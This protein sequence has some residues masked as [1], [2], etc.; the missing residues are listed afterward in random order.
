MLKNLLIV[1]LALCAIIAGAG[2][3]VYANRSMLADK[4]VAYA[5]NNLAG[6]SSQTQSEA[7]TWTDT[8]MQAGMKSLQKSVKNAVDKQSSEGQRRNKNDGLATM[9]DMF[10][11]A[12][13]SDSDNLGQMAQVLL[14]EFGNSAGVN[15]S[16]LSA[17]TA[18]D[19]NARD[20]K[21]RTLLMNV[22]RVDVTPRVVKMLLKQGADDH[23]GRSALMYAA[24]LNKNPEVVSCLLNNGA[25]VSVV[26]AE[27]KSVFEYATDDEIRQILRKYAR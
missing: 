19:V 17:E 2:Y 24:A 4:L 12:T 7:S 8:L 6:G 27:N 14:R 10:A 11:N 9:A 3:Y 15:T 26:D 18:H 20:G 16:S 13:N 5:M 1:L 25:D 22:C 23:K 21:G